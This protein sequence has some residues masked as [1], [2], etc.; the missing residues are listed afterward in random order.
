MTNGTTASSACNK[1]Q[2]LTQG[3]IEDQDSAWKILEANILP[4]IISKEERSSDFK[5]G[6]ASPAACFYF[7]LARLWAALAPCAV[8]EPWHIHL[9]LNHMHE[10]MEHEDLRAWKGL[11][12]FL[13]RCTALAKKYVFPS[14]LKEPFYPIIPATEPEHKT[15]EN[16]I[17]FYPNLMHKVILKIE[18]TNL[19][20]DTSDCTRNAFP[21]SI[22]I[23]I[24]KHH[25]S[26][27]GFK[28]P[29]LKAFFILNWQ[30]FFYPLRVSINDIKTEH[31]T[32]QR[33]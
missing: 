25:Y 4:S 24:T 31:R 30:Q 9:P 22:L 6:W 32:S 10:T 29:L 1:G 33:Y 26:D 27:S 5:V 17:Y 28:P 2:K 23:T 19:E 15:V 13:I 18:D 3:T 11:W 8:P 21:H 16:V 12:G 7:L 14:F 20:M